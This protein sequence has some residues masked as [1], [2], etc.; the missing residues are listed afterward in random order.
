ME[1]LLNG[2]NRGKLLCLSTCLTCES[3]SQCSQL[4]CVFPGFVYSNA[5]LKLVSGLSPVPDCLLSLT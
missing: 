4:T 5:C 1:L 2:K 3:L